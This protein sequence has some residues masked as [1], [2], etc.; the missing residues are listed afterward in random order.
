MH[1]AECRTIF[2][3]ASCF[4]YH[5]CPSLRA[6]CRW[7]LVRATNDVVS[8]S[9]TPPPKKPPKNHQTKSKIRMPPRIAVALLFRRSFF[10]ITLRRSLC[11]R[12]RSTATRCGAS[13][14]ST[15]TWSSGRSPSP[16]PLNPLRTPLDHRTPQCCVVMCGVLFVFG[17]GGRG[18]RG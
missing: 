1:Q 8:T 4:V 6:G 14:R 13:C 2:F 3:L 10:H 12:R 15:P 5:I 9:A 17:G 16:T 7:I 18:G 11:G